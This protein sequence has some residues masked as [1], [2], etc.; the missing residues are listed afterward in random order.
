MKEELGF[1][2]KRADKFRKYADDAFKKGDYDMAAFNTEQSLQLYLK[3]TL[4]MLLGDFPRTH[5]ISRLLNN[6]SKASGDK[7][8]SAFVE[9]EP[10]IVSNLEEVY[11]TARYLPSEFTEKQV[12]KLIAF[13]ENVLKKLKTLWSW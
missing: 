11:L 3:Y 5:S 13:S 9:K 8:F 7:T 4:G 12:A 10:N 2:R 1:L 6:I